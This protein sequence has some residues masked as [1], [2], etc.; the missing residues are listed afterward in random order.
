MSEPIEMLRGNERKTVYGP[1]SLSNA[2]ADGWQKVKDLTPEE[3]K[4]LAELPPTPWQGYADMTA[5]DIVARL[6]GLT[7]GKRQEVIAYESATAQRATIL[8][9]L[10]G[11]P[12]VE[13]VTSEGKVASGKRSSGGAGI[14]KQ[15]EAETGH[16]VVKSGSNP[17]TFV[18][19]DAPAPSE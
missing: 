4:R 9:K 12:K 18:E 7:P 3:Q 6:E 8:D 16:D 1:A 10:T 13:P 5:H 19:T 14:E 2:I 11:K 17:P 15:L